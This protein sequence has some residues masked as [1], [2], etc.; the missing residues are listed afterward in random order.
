MGP[1]FLLIMLSTFAYFVSVGALIPTLP[2]FIEG[3]L[4][5]SDV[6]VGLGIGMFSLSAVLAR[7]FVGQVGDRRGRRILMVAGGLLVGLGTLAYVVADALVPLLVLRFISGAGEAAFYVG[8]ASVIND[9]AP[10]ERRGEALSYFSLALY[11]GLAVGPVLGETVM[12]GATFDAAWIVSGA[13]AL[14][15]TLLVLRLPDTR[16]EYNGDRKPTKRGR[17][18]HPAGVIPGFILATA[19]IGLSGFSAFVPLYT[20][21][22]GMTG[23]R[24]VFVLNS[25]VVLTV[26]FF[27]A[28]IPD[29]LGARTTVRFGLTTNVVGF[30]LIALWAEPI[31]LY[32]GTI[33]FALGHSLVFPALMTMAVDAAPSHERGAVVGTFTAFFDLAFGGGAVAL[34]V[35][36]NLFGYGGVF[37]TSSLVALGGLVLL[38]KTTTPGR[39][40]RVPVTD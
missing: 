25:V 39:I 1:L 35:V 37:V 19:I 36:A 27:G 31:G 2:R 17:I 20:L 8:A 4:D 23:S 13:A 14:L 18:V 5:G 15:A 34:G 7:P 6:A 30:A 40:A 33:M 38:L 22:I 24:M 26:R 21:S 12:Q 11:A 32:L 9:L 28:R 10:D 3:P 29:R 16:P